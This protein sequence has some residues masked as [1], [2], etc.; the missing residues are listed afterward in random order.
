MSDKTK[1]SSHCRLCRQFSDKTAIYKCDQ[2]KHTK[3]HYGKKAIGWLMMYF[4]GNTNVYNV[5]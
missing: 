5:C 2:M 4:G 3:E 1:T